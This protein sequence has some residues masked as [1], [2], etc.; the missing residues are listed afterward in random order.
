[1]TP[2]HPHE[3]EARYRATD[4]AAFALIRREELTEEARL[5]Y[6][7]EVLRRNS[8]ELLSKLYL[9]MDDNEF[10]CL[11]REGIPENAKKWFDEEH[12]RRAAPEYVKEGQQNFV[13]DV[14]YKKAPGLALLLIC[15]T[16]TLT[17]LA[18]GINPGLIVLIAA[19]ASFR[20]LTGVAY[21]VDNTKREVV[22]HALVGPFKRRVRYTSLAAEGDVVFFVPEKKGDR[23]RL[24]SLLYSKKDL[25]ALRKR[26]MNC[27]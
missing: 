16:W 22:Y 17:S 3:I 8:D 18:Y 5:H 27:G 14:R 15:G 1:M 9:S 7:R 6:D 25:G 23:K 24:P 12:L 20:Y 4:D 26:I 2:T 11:S 19:V 13:V 10:R 21:S